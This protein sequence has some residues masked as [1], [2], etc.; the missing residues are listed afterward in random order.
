EPRLRVVEEGHGAAHALNADLEGDARA[1]RGL[2]ED[3]REKFAAQRRGVP[4]GMRLDVRGELQEFARLRGAPF[5][6]GEQVVD[7]QNRC[8]ERCCWHFFLY[9]AAERA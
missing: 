9:F 3:Q 8:S 2:L 4:G 1:Q 6:S 5:R 7:E